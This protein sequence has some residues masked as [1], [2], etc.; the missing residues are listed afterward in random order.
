M[1]TILCDFDDTAADCNVGQSILVHFQ[2]DPS[3]RGVLPWEDIRSKYTERQISLA[4]YQELAFQ[5]LDCSRLSI[6]EFV[7]NSHPIRLGFKELSTYSKNNDVTLAI[8]SHGLDFYIQAALDSEEIMI[9]IHAVTTF[10]ERSEMSFEY[11][12]SDKSCFAWPGNCKCKMLEQYRNSTDLIIYVG[13][14]ISD[15]CPALKADYV[16]ARDWLVGF[17]VENDV[18]FQEFSDFYDIINYVKTLKE[19]TND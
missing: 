15:S 7:K 17:C 8:T 6:I 4:E 19:N 13:D 2:P 12:Y 1:L 11:P 3:T 18:K 14:S 10:G 5:Q 16:F 9:P